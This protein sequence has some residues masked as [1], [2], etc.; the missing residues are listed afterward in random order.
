M[1]QIFDGDG[2]GTIALNELADVMKKLGRR[3]PEA[4]LACAMGLD[5][6][7]ANQG[8]RSFDPGNV[9]LDFVSFVNMLAGEH[10]PSCASC[11]T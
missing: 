7:L 9:E 5:E 1:F 11:H 8:A 10:M 6:L 4:E 2:G 3:P